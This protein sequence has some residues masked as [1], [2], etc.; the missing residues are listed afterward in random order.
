MTVHELKTWSE[1]YRAIARGDKKHEL[2]KN[3]RGFKLGD[4]LHLREWLAIGKGDYTGHSI[5]V[6]VTYVSEPSTMNGLQEGYCCMSIAL[7]ERKL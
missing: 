3:D 6:E 1:Y 5:V 4:H 2:R 7:L